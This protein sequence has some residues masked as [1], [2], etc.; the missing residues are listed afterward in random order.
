MKKQA[1]NLSKGCSPKWVLISCLV[2]WGVGTSDAAEKTC[3][4]NE[5]STGTNLCEA[6]PKQY[7]YLVN[8]DPDSLF[9]TCVRTRTATFCESSPKDFLWVISKAKEKVCVQTYE[10]GFSDFCTTQPKNYSWVLVEGGTS[11]SP[12][13]SFFQ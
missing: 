5:L 7:T 2:W 9:E 3:V 11:L 8:V 1:N 12:L 10:N 4:K 6:F 13:H